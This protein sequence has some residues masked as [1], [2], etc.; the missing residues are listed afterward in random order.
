MNM[1]IAMPASSSGRVFERNTLV[2]H[3]ITGTHA[4]TSLAE[5]RRLPEKDG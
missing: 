2:L 4:L 5:S 1:A 3:I